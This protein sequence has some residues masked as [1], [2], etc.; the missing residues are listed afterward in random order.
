[1]NFVKGYFQGPMFFSNSNLQISRS[2]FKNNNVSTLLYM[3]DGDFLKIDN[4]TFVENS[5]TVRTHFVINFFI[6]LLEKLNKSL[7]YFVDASLQMSTL[8]TWL[9]QQFQAHLS[10]KIRS[11]Y[12][13]FKKVIILNS[14]M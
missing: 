7:G 10:E 3:S 12:C 1:M 9:G 11:V 13:L 8:L 2:S 6:R 4:V 5:A 14:Q